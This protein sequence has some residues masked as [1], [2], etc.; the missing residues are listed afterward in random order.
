MQTNTTKLCWSHIALA[1]LCSFTTN[2]VF[3]RVNARANF[4]HA[5]KHQ[6]TLLE[7]YCLGQTLFIHNKRSFSTGDRRTNFAHQSKHQQTLLE[8]IALTELCSYKTN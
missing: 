1:K 8:N 5:S 7:P 2:E 6:Q 4:A 3:P